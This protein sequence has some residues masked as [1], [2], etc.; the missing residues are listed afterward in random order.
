MRT[1]NTILGSVA[2][3]LASS[4][5]AEAQN[6]VAGPLT[7]IT[8]PGTI[9]CSALNTSSAALAVVQIRIFDRVGNPPPPAGIATCAGQNC[10]T[11]NSLAANH[12]C[13][14]GPIYPGETGPFSCY[15]YTDPDPIAPIRGALCATFSDST[16]CLPAD[17]FP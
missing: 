13:S 16:A 7:A 6:M 4:A 15:I 12:T 3:M 11:C 10:T 14:L 9:T 2:L 1:V 17:E 8:Y 5:G